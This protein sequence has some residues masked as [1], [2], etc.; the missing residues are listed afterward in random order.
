MIKAMQSITVSTL[1][2]SALPAQASETVHKCESY[3]AKLEIFQVG[4]D[5]YRAVLSGAD[6]NYLI[7]EQG[8]PTLAEGTRWSLGSTFDAIKVLPKFVDLENTDGQDTV[9]IHDLK[10]LQTLEGDLFGY[11]W[12]PFENVIKQEPTGLQYRLHGYEGGPELETYFY[13]FGNWFFPDCF[14]V[15]NLNERVF[16][17]F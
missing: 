16:P 1:V 11:Y 9:V 17:R 5:N 15:E 4:E 13:N 12:A 14:L 7:G 10:K 2:L 6:A 8:Q 3:G